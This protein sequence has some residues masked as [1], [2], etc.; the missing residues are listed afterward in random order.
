MTVQHLSDEAV[1]AFADGV[2]SGHARD[3]A[4]RHLNECPEC[5]GAVKEQ[6]EAAAVLRTAAAPALPTN[7]IDRLRTLP[8]TTP[9]PAPPPQ[10]ISD[11]GEA[12]LPTFAP[13]AAAF[14][15]SAPDHRTRGRTYLTAAV[16][17]GVTGALVAGGAALAS[18][19]DHH[20]APAVH[21][22]H[23]VSTG[24]AGSLAPVTF[25]GRS[26]H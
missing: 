15:P 2:L 14:V 4:A 23:H 6:R 13:M 16:L 9:L 21:P 8:L 24:G 3:R 12:V 19:N 18:E 7:L 11:E 25:H 17:L 20:P 5:R 22:V 1:A 26:G 10:A